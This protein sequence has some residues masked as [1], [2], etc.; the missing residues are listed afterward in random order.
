MAHVIILTGGIEQPE[1]IPRIRR[2]LGAYRV[3]SAIESNGYSVVVIDY[4]Q[5]MTAEEII[6]VLEKHVTQETLWFGY[7]STFFYAQKNTFGVPLTP[8]EKMYQNTDYEKIKT[9]YS[10]IKHNSNAKIVFGGA[11]ALFPPADP[12]VDYY[13]TG[14]ADNVVVNLTNYLA[15]KESLLHPTENAV[16]TITLNDKD[17]PEPAMC[18]LKTRWQYLLPGEPTPLEFARGCIFKC[19]FCNYPLIGKRKGTYIRDMQ[20]VKEEL[21]EQWETFGTDT[22]YIT[23]DTF[24]DDNDKM[25]EFHK[26][27]TSLPFKPKFSAF[28]RLDLMDRFPHQADLLSEAGIVGTFFGIETF[29]LKS[30]RSIGKGLNPDKVKSRLHWVADKWKGQANIGVGLIVGLP[31]DDEKYFKELYDYVNSSDYP[32]HFTT[33]NPLYIFDQRRGTGLYGSE[34]SLHPEVYGYKFDDNG[35]WYHEEQ[36]IDF[37]RCL[38]VANIIGHSIS[39][40]QKIADF[41]MVMYLGMGVKKE[42]L[43]KYTEQE[44][45]TMYDFKQLNQNKLNLYKQMI[46]VKS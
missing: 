19:K 11:M 15:G 28:L 41:L 20:Q 44:I 46:G 32:A 10:F 27:F 31:H 36:Q 24:N 2:H 34:F 30:G 13:I 17:Y 26:L 23:D 14:Y 1:H 25:E 43:L 39:H 45:L 22:Y 21:I 6:S 9:I 7:S 38:E 33:V 16:G 37:Y 3:A 18:D 42:D 29:N 40:K 5:Y 12:L 35:K 4:S 8:L